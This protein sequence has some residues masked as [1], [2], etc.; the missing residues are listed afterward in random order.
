MKTIL[1]VLLLTGCA[2]PAPDGYWTNDGTGAMVYEEY[3][4]VACSDYTISSNSGRKH[5]L[6]CQIR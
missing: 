2:G 6:S 5:A 4:H 3:S 1:L